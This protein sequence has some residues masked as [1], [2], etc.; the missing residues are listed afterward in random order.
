MCLFILFIYILFFCAYFL[1]GV[2]LCFFKDLFSFKSMC[3]SIYVQCTCMHPE[4]LEEGL[5]S[6]GARLRGGYA[7]LMSGLGY[8]REYSGRASSTHDC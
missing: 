7:Y 1:F 2:V 6:S 4:R 3:A 5:R 8:E